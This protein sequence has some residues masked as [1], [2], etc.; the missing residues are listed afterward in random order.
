MSGLSSLFVRNW[1]LK[2]AAFGLAVVLW[3]VVQADPR[4]EG[5][6]QTLADVPLAV[7]VGDLGWTLQ[8]DPSPPSVQVRVRSVGSVIL[9]GGPDDAVVRVPVDTVLG[10]DTVLQLRA[11]WVQLEGRGTYVI[12]DIIPAT[13][14]LSF[15]RTASAL[16]PVAVRTQGELPEGEALATPIGLEPQAIRVRGP[17][18]QIERLDSLVLQPFDLSTVEQSGIYEVP[19]DTTALGDVSLSS[20]TA[21]LGVRLEPSAER[22]L[23]GVPVSVDTAAAV[24]DSVEVVPPTLQVTLRGARSR[25]AAAQGGQV[26][27]VI[28]AA[29]VEGLEAGYQRTVPIVLR[30]VPELVRAFAPVDSVTVRRPPAGAEDGRDAPLPPDPSG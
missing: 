28:P 1:R 14:R 4:I 15:Q 3:A 13:V 8:G 26:R 23:A 5:S 9:P 21:R 29:A 27:A 17:E 18:R 20:S 19:V 24:A 25:L 16:V 12:T 10:Q 6:L 2:L 30:G 7:Q 11:D 22:V